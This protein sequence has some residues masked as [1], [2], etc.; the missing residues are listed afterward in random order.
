[1]YNEKTNEKESIQTEKSHSNRKDTIKTEKTEK[2]AT[3]SKKHLQPKKVAIQMERGQTIFF[4][5]KKEALQPE[6][7]PYKQKRSRK[8]VNFPIQTEQR[9]YKQKRP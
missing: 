4:F 9:P 6:K 2:K 5:K 8:N 3:Y 7:R 1:M